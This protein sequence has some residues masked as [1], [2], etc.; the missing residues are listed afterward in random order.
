MRGTGIVSDVEIYAT[1]QSN[2]H[3]YME[4]KRCGSIETEITATSICGIRP[5]LA[6]LNLLEVLIYVRSNKTY[7]VV[8][9]LKRVYSHT[10][11]NKVM[12]F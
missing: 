5:L 10:H 1:K 3:Q 4:L 12:I 6:I 11:K 9:G 7:I 2:E 8:H